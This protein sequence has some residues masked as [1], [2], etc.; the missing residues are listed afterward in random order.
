MTTGRDFIV[1]VR[2]FYD[3]RSRSLNAISKKKCDILF[4]LNG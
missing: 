1:K 2:D 3:D 4:I